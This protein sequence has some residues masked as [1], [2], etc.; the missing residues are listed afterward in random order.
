MRA[1][2]LGRTSARR[3]LRSGERTAAAAVHGRREGHQQRRKIRHPQTLG[4]N[5][6]KAGQNR[7]GGARRIG[8]MVVLGDQVVAAKAGA[9]G[10]G[11]AQ[12]RRQAPPGCA[13]RLKV[14]VH[15]RGAGWFELRR[16]SLCGRRCRQVPTVAGIIAGNANFSSGDE[17]PADAGGDGLRREPQV[18]CVALCAPFA[19]HIPAERARI[20]RGR[21]ICLPQPSRA[22]QDAA[23][24]RTGGNGL[25]A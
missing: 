16:Q 5:P 11:P 4:A 14:L 3:P 15:L 9:G 10:L 20:W 23:P 22:G 12:G 24:G 17:R 21:L 7:P 25:A 6:A 8:G 19:L 1:L 18:G 2:P 13:R